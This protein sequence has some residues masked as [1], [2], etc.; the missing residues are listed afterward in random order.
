M[1]ITNGGDVLIVPTQRGQNKPKRLTHNGVAQGSHGHGH[2][3]F[4]RMCV[5]G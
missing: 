2:A 3:R 4:Q 1:H 5:R